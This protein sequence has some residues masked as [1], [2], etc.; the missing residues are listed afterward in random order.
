MHKILFYTDTPNLGGAEKQIYLL[1]KYLDK[2]KFEPVLVYGKYSKFN[3]LSEKI[4]Q[5]GTKIIKLNTSHK[6][7]PRN[8]F[9]LK[10]II[11]KEKP[12]LVHIH[13]WNPASCR[14]G[15]LASRKYKTIVTEHD[16]FP[17]AGIKD[18]IKNLLSRNISQLISISKNN[19]VPNALKSKNNIIYNGI[20]IEEFKSTKPEPIPEIKENDNVITFVGELH[21]RKGIQYLIQAFKQLQI[22][23]KKL[24]IVG[25]GPHK[26]FFTKLANNNPNIHFLGRRS[27]IFNILQKSTIFVLPSKREAFGLVL[28][29][30]M[31]ANTPIIGSSTGGIKEIIKNNENGL[32]FENE[33]TND[34][35]EKIEKLINNKDLQQKL[36]K[37]ASED[38]QKNYTAREMTR[39]TEKLYL[40]TINQ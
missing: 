39:N 3:E 35:T 21:K 29:E 27:D 12:D 34:L 17:L 5:T 15:L 24:L 6:H 33:N 26:D 19:F 13:L 2:T 4:Q 36:T 25:S 7:D 9:Q 38:L 28:L 37:N 20:D 14:W 22:P 1:L 32:L 10:K 8:Y 30:A 11:K 40:K 18:L 16:P 23:N 31:A